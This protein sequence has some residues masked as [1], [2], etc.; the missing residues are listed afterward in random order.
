MSDVRVGGRRRIDRVLAPDYLA[1]LSDLP[2]DRIVAKRAEADSEEAELAYLAHLLDGRIEVVLAEQSRRA[3]GSDATAPDVLTNG[4]LLGP[5]WRSRMFRARIPDPLP[6]ERHRRR[7]ERLVHDV[8]LSDVTARSD[9]ELDRVLRTYRAEERKVA[10]LRGRV[11]EVARRCADE[12]ARR[13]G[14]A[15][16]GADPA[17]GRESPP[18]PGSPE[19]PNGIPT[20]SASGSPPAPPPA[21][22]RARGG[23]RG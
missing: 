22:S 13:A 8:D 10:D 9:G 21:G 18:S 17:G 2:A 5:A 20:E 14:A 23:D 16:G 11:A 15:A 6:P 12:L 19:S 4:S 1:G 3:D 7:V